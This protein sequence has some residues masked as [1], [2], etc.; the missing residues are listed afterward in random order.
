[1]D[2]GIKIQVLKDNRKLLESKFMAKQI[3]RKLPQNLQK[4]NCIKICT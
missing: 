4:H 2:L 1:M 3:I